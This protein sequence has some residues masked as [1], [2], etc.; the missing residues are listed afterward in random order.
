MDVLFERCCGLD[1]HKRTIAGC[2][3]TP[4]ERGRPRKEVR[5][6]ETTVAQFLALGGWMV[7]EGVTHVAMERT[8]VYWKPVYNLLEERFTFLL[9]NAHHLKLGLAQDI[10]TWRDT[11]EVGF[12]CQRLP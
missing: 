5:S 10:W 3:C 11:P 6:L 1:I 12:V 9:A 2:V 8:G 7:E 4:G